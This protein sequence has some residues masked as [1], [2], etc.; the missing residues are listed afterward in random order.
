MVATQSRPAVNPYLILEPSIILAPA[1]E[2]P[3][4]ESG[5]SAQLP[6]STRESP[7]ARGTISR[8]SRTRNFW[9]AKIE[10]Y[11]KISR[12]H[13]KA[14]IH[15]TR[16]TCMLVQGEWQAKVKPWFRCNNQPTWCLCKLAACFVDQLDNASAQA[17]TLS[18]W[19][20]ILRARLISRF[21][22]FL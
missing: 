6:L 1:N 3:I 21:I 10:W 5:V 12:S 19:T 20:T 16:F 17:S 14:S 13:G 7:P 9:P 11:I 22:S 18:A 2:A 15:L 4:G 8:I